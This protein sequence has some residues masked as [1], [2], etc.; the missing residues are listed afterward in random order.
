MEVTR[1]TRV[2][3]TIGILLALVAGAWF[4]REMVVAAVQEGPGLGWAAALVVVVLVVGERFTRAWMMRHAIGR[5]SHAEGFAVHDVGAAANYGL[6]AGGVIGTGLRYRIAQRAGVEPAPFLAGITVFGIAMAAS[7]WLLPIVFLSGELLF[8]SGEALDL[9]L[10]AVALVVLASASLLWWALLGSERVFV[11]VVGVVQW[12]ADRVG[13]RVAAVREFDA[14]S[15]LGSLRMQTRGGLGRLPVLL[16]GSLVAQTLAAAIL[17]V[18]LHAVSGDLDLTLVDFGRVFFV[19]RV[20]SSLVP[21]PGGVGAVEAGLSASLVAAGVPAASALAG[22]L[23]YRLATFVLPIV[24]GA[25]C[26]CLFARRGSR[27]GD[28]ELDPSA[29]PSDRVLAVPVSPGGGTLLREPAGS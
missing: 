17:L 24:T 3:T 8:G 26:W 14:E 18:S 12:A 29:M 25:V 5:L 6:P 15:A 7:S 27:S 19:T 1:R 21:T 16:V 11:R 13:R 10:L 22:I 23:V 9:G 2:L 20:V 4:Q 28:P